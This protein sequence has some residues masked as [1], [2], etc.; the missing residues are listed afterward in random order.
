MYPQ[1][2][3]RDRSDNT[4]QPTWGIAHKLSDLLES[5]LCGTGQILHI[6]LKPHRNRR[7]T[8]NRIDD[9]LGKPL[10]PA[11]LRGFIHRYTYCGRI[12]NGTF[13][14]DRFMPT[15]WHQQIRQLVMN[16]ATILTV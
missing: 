13:D 5:G 4:G 14:T 10:P 6:T 12:L 15:I 9:P 16:P 11:I 3:I 8:T 2:E 7:E 1:M